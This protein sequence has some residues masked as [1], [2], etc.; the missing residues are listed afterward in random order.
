M[1]SVAWLFES[2]IYRRSDVLFFCSFEVKLDEIFQTPVLD[3][4]VSD[5]FKAGI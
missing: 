4:K 1:N 5:S 2:L 3:N